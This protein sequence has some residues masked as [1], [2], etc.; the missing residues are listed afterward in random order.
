LP[1]DKSTTGH[2]GPRPLAW[3]VRSDRQKRSG[4]HDVN[5]QAM[6]KARICHT[7]PKLS[8]RSPSIVD[9]CGLLCTLDYCIKSS[10]GT[11][12]HRDA[13]SSVQIHQ[14]SEESKFNS[15]NA[16]SATFESPLVTPLTY[17]PSRVLSTDVYFTEYYRLSLK[18]LLL[19]RLS[20][21]SDS[22]VIQAHKCLCLVFH[23]YLQRL[24][25]H[26]CRQCDA[27]KLGFCPDANDL[28]ATTHDPYRRTSSTISY[29][30]RTRIAM[31]HVTTLR[32][33]R[34]HIPTLRRA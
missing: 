30:H 27:T 33:R 24:R 11:D 21:N 22:A 12:R 13:P 19:A 3:N 4:E 8:S 5:S 18:C 26:T 7:G 16:S 34:L 10:R 20:L 14:A 32:A 9:D 23:S 28:S 17:L 15:E 2:A 25:S 31:L 6:T 29:S 1:P